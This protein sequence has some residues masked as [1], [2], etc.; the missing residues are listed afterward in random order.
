[1]IVRNVEGNIALT[2]AGSREAQ[3]PE[4]PE[5]RISDSWHVLFNIDCPQLI[6]S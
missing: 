5:N 1:M 6:A 4:F 3:T 2:Q